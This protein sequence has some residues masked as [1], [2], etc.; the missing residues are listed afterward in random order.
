MATLSV[1]EQL[2]VLSEFSFTASDLEGALPK[3]DN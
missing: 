1:E 3:I 2:D